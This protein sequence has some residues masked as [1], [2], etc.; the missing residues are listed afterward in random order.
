MKYRY[1]EV[2]A[3][4]E[5]PAASGRGRIREHVLIAEIAL[6]KRLPRGVHVHHV[7]LNDTNNHNGNLVVCQDAAYHSLLHLRTK[8]LGTCGHADWYKCYLCKGY[9]PREEMCLA[10]RG[11]GRTEQASHH[12]CAAADMAA[13]RRARGVP[14]RGLRGRY[15]TRPHT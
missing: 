12:A 13:R 6:G 11:A 8:A 2:P 7:D 15:K 3:P 9:S 5:H 1:I 4:A 10:R 14:A